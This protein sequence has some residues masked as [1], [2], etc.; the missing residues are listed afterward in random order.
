MPQSQSVLGPVQA[1]NQINSTAEISRQITLL[2][3]QKSSV[4][5]G[6]L[7]VIPVGDSLI[8]VR[9]LY[10][11]REGA[12]GYPTF[13]FVIVLAPGKEPVLAATV[14]DGLNQIFGAAPAAPTPGQTT[15][16]PSTG[17]TVADLLNQAS[18]AFNAA[19][20]ALKNGDLAEY[21][22]DINQAGKLIDQAAKA[23]AAT[24]TTPSSPTTP[25]TPT[26]GPSTPAST[27]APAS[28]Q[29]AGRRR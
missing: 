11:Q 20:A 9:P 21:Q 25:T 12:S 7:Q 17:G 16:T 28:T 23:A 6:S 13:R 5:Q 10:V 19:Q 15:P 24:P 29:Q 22:K 3:Q 1:D 27:A 18:A 14:N 4:E 8:Y 26:T 2:G